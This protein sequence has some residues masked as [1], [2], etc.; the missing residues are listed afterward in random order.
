MLL[1][2]LNYM[3]SILLQGKQKKQ[4]LRSFNSCSKTLEFFIAL[5]RYQAVHWLECLVG[6][7][8]I[9]DQPSEREFISCLR[10]GLILC[11][12]INKIQPGSVPKSFAGCGESFT[13]SISDMGSQPLPTYQYFENIRN[14]LVAVEVL[15]LPAFKASDIE[16]E[17][18]E[19]GLVAR[20]VD[21]ILA[22]KSYHEL[23]QINWGHGSNK[24]VK[25]PLVLH[26]AS[27]NFS[28]RPNALSTEPCRC[29]D[30]STGFSKESH[31][32][33]T[34]KALTD[35]MVDAKEN[36]DNNFLASLHE[37][38]LSA[39]VSKGNRPA[40][41]V[42]GYSF[43]TSEFGLYCYLP[44]LSVPFSDEVFKDTR[45]LMRSVMDGYNVCIFAYG[46]TGSGKTYTVCGP[47][48]GLAKDM[49]I[50]YFTLNDLFQLSKQRKDIRSYNIY[51][52][53]FEIYNEQVRDLLTEDLSSTKYPLSWLEIRS[54]H[55][56]DGLSLPDAT[57]H[58]VKST[59]DVLNLM[60]H[61]DENH[62]VNFTAMNNQSSHSHRSYSWHGY[63]GGH[64]KTLMFAHV[65]PEGD[66]FGETLSTLKFAQRVS[67]FELGA[68]CLNKQSSEVREFK[69]QFLVYNSEDLDFMQIENLKKA[70]VK[71]V[72]YAESG[73]TE[74]EKS[75]CG[76]KMGMPQRT[77]QSRLLSHENP[78]AMKSDKLMKT[79]NKKSYKTPS[80]ATKHGNEPSFSCGECLGQ[81][82]IATP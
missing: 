56:N 80:L 62:A 61:G 64:V 22:L 27:K 66:D 31:E 26:S 69:Q 68:T 24:H 79:A 77:P 16:T 1:E 67:G 49:G 43:S 18:F 4:L 72:Q 41:D 60:K 45:P 3:T 48:G 71:K 7:L 42:T 59:I 46:Q 13:Y 12:A 33:Y 52:Q 37:R 25:S 6:P 23:K 78:S 29:L 55:T 21:C 58:S 44:G 82:N 35:I 76:D 81:N 70:L 75:P 54:H 19:A 63:I 40:K 8:G 15:K 74:E 73:K 36:I 39:S 20:I 57:L 14:F 17:T 65:S 11:N 9:S 5:R 2:V 28:R 34:V 30:M 47:S 10:N 38:N 51:V 53:M 50:N 32:E